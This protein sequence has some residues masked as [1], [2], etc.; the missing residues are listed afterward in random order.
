MSVFIEELNKTTHKIDETTS[1]VYNVTHTQVPSS[2][3]QEV[4]RAEIESQKLISMLHG[5]MAPIG[6]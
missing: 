1:M 2:L 3:E 6:D 4:C 5:Y